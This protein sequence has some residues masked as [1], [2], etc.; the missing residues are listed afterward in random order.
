MN[1]HHGESPLTFLL[2][3]A[4]SK[5]AHFM[6]HTVTAQLQ[7]DNDAGD[8]ARMAHFRL[9]RGSGTGGSLGGPQNWLISSAL[10]LPT[11]LAA[12]ASANSLTGM[13]R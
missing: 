9:M 6:M 5:Q 8:R 11:A 12:K 1:C 10:R 13:K 2:A 3:K 4:P 7:T